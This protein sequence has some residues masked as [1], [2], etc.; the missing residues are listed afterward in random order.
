MTRFETLPADW[1]SV[2]EA[3]RA[4]LAHADLL[5]RERVPMADALGRALAEDLA[6]RTAL[7]PWD[8]AAM[9]GYAVR[10]ADIADATDEHPRSLSV[11]GQVRA[12]D[13]P[14]RELGDGQAIRIMTGAPVPPGADS[15]VRVEDTDA[16]GTE[17]TVVVIRNRD[18]GRNVRPGGEDMRPG[19]VLLRA[20][21]RVGPG[22]VGVL[23]SLGADTVPVR[24][25]PRVGVLSNGDELAPLDGYQRVLDGTAIPESNGPMLAAAVAEAGGIAVPLGIALDTEESVEAH[26]RQALEADLDVLVTAA[27]A[28][29]GESDLFKRVMDRL[30]RTEFL[31]HLG[32]ENVYLSIHDAMQSIGPKYKKTV[33]LDA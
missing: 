5:P 12:G 10:A 1:L 23:A 29:M 3:H 27:G 21:C 25:R 8:N 22:H 2:D 16:E 19:D 28:S 11:I 14:D 24:R 20:G 15:V 26:L 13:L 33:A 4:I 32:D 18:A 31:R 7:P 17:G 6:A 30:G 9:D